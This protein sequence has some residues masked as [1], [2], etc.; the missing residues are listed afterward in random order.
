MNHIWS[1]T[2]AS[3]LV[4]LSTTAY[5]IDDLSFDCKGRLENT[6]TKMDVPI[7]SRGMLLDGMAL[8]LN[9]SS[10]ALA[11]VGLI[12][13]NVSASDEKWIRFNVS[14]DYSIDGKKAL[15]GIINRTDGSITIQFGDPQGMYLA[16]LKCVVDVKKPK[17]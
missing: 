6:D 3:L 11:H 12:G 14:N 7:S 1:F 16:W 5:A 15:K 9:L 4:V 17:F 13:G 10:P 2:I 8:T